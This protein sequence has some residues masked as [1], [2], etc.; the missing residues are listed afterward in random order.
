MQYRNACVGLFFALSGCVGLVDSGDAGTGGGSNDGKGDNP[1]GSNPGGGTATP[2]ASDPVTQAMTGS[3]MTYDVGPGKTYADPDT[4]PWSKLVAGDVVN[5]YYRA[6]AYKSKLCIRG[7][8]TAAAP[9]VVNG[10]TDAS[11]RRPVFEFGGART[12]SGCNLG[13][14]DN[15]FNV[16]SQYSLEDYGGIMIKG[17]TGDPYGYK[18]A[19]IHIKNLE[20]VGAKRGASFVN[21]SGQSTPYM[22]SPAAI[23]IQPSADVVVENNV[24][25]DNGFGV[26]TMAK[27]SILDEACERIV[28]RNNRIFGNGIV[29]SFLEHNV[30]MQSTNPLIEGNYFG[31]TRAGSEGS[32]Y[33]SRSSGEV[34]RYNY[35]EASARA[36]DWVHAEDQEEGIGK[37]SDYGTDYAYGNIIVNDCGLGNCASNPIHYGGDNGGEQEN[38]S[39]EFR[40]PVPYRSKLM[41]YNNTVIQRT[42]QNEVWRATAFDLSLRGSTVEAWNNIFSF[43]GTSDYGWVEIAGKVNLRGTNLV[44]GTVAD[45]QDVALP[46]N[47]TITKSQLETGTAPF[48]SATDMH[49]AAASAA[50]DKATTVPTGVTANGAYMHTPVSMQPNL[51]S[52]GMTARQTKGA[53]ADLGALE[54]P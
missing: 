45:A 34:F 36:I 27:N 42:K 11:G 47:Y 30:Y 3:H 52:N 21:L 14:N 37:Q 28:V 33:K 35:V 22:E 38:D 32:T 49:P 5:I 2:A 20:L 23:W 44:V 54:A 41:F 39:T 25:R 7:K 16:G 10:V 18:P 48:V 8:G 53:A 46:V 31:I 1:G 40:P 50:I 13:G 17:G 24:I 9:I 6:E 43:E 29:G 4:V 26:F 12:A 51:R 19:H 15:I